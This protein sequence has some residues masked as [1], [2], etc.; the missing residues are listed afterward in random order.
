MV[1]TG[2]L[3]WAGVGNKDV[4]DPSYGSVRDFDRAF[5]LVDA[6]AGG[7]VERVRQGRF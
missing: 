4:P 6:A 3:D 1:D 7:I 5:R 2:L